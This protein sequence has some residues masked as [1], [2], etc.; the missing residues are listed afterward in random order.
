MTIEIRLSPD[1]TDRLA[2]VLAAHNAAH[3]DDALTF[4]ELAEQLLVDAIWTAA[5]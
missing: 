2:E 3:P 5:T 4:R 1:D